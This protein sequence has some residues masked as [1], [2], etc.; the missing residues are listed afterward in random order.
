MSQRVVYEYFIPDYFMTV[1][2]SPFKLQLSDKA[3]WLIFCLPFQVFNSELLGEHVHPSLSLENGKSDETEMTPKRINS[4][5]HLQLQICVD[6]FNSNLPKGLDCWFC[7]Y[8]SSDFLNS[9]CGKK[10]KE[11]LISVLVMNHLCATFT[12]WI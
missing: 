1:W 4:V 9:S 7:C 11:F 6:S 12:A 2:N 3:V 5:L 10:K 8:F